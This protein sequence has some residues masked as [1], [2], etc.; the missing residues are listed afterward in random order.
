MWHTQKSTDWVSSVLFDY[1]SIRKMQQVL[2]LSWLRCW[3]G[4]RHSC[5][6]IQRDSV[7]PSAGGEYRRDLLHRQRGVVRHLFPHVETKHSN[8]R[9]PQPPRVG[10][11]VWCHHMPTF[12]RPGLHSWILPLC[13]WELLYHYWQNWHWQWFDTLRKSLF[14][15]RLQA[16]ILV[17]LSH[18]VT[19]DFFFCLLCFYFF[20]NRLA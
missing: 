19:D 18:S 5:R 17:K 20:C 10:H 6:A 9:R 2:T 15:C 7:G 4:F 16:T 12:P 11:H 13:V 14:D 3:A 8:I 1:A